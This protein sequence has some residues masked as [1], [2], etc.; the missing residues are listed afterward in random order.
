MDALSSQ[1]T[2]AG[3]YAVLL[4]TVHMPKILPMMTTAVGS[5]RA[6]QVL[7]MGL[8]VAGL[9]A[10]AT[11]GRLGAVTEGYDVRPETKEEAHSLG[12][13]FVETGVDATGQGGYAR[14]LTAEEKVKVKGVLS[15][16]I[17]RA[18]L[19]VT[20]AAVPGRKAPRL[21]DAEQISKMKPGSVIID[22]G[23]EGGGNCEGTVAGQSVQVGP[24]LL[25][26]PVNLPSCL[27]EQASELYSKNILNLLQQ[28]IKDGKLSLDMTDEVIAKTLVTHDGKITNDGVREA[29]EGPAPTS[30]APAP[31]AG[32]TPTTG[33]KG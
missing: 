7:V 22:M 5:L 28:I 11:A 4:G 16:H 23:A 19:I 26:G 29:V 2:L 33:S 9:Q 32:A 3:Y 20:T 1:A 24:T 21:I 6:A 31:A 15:D 30:S 25:V 10:L 13:K 12:A 27:S 17:A 18:D 14:E 8:G